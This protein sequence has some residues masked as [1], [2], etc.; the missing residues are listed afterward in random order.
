MVGCHAEH[1]HFIQYKL[2]RSIVETGRRLTLTRKYSA[3]FIM[4]TANVLRLTL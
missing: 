3:E 1:I 4:S 2:R